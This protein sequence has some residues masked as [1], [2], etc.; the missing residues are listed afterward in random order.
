MGKHA[1][2]YLKE[3]R[4]K[5]YTGDYV[6]QAIRE[7]DEAEAELAKLTRAENEETAVDG[8]VEGPPPVNFVTGFAVVMSPDGDTVIVGLTPESLPSLTVLRQPSA[9]EVRRMSHDVY[10]FESARKIAHFVRLALMPPP[11]EADP[12]P[13]HTH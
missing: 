8:P 2:A 4:A 13:D 7:R 9:D 12:E 6:P 11:A 10:E 3:W 5:G 1:E